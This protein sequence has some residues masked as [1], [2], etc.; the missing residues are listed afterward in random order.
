LNFFEIKIVTSIK[1]GH[2]LR[3]WPNHENSGHVLF[4]YLKYL[5]ALKKKVL[6]FYHKIKPKSE[7]EK[8]VNM[9]K[10]KRDVIKR[11]P[12]A[13]LHTKPIP[14]IHERQFP[15]RGWLCLVWPPLHTT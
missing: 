12:F 14:A 7:T 8:N 9:K 4:G 6:L 3:I 2:L 1:L 5:K 11:K 15:L 13:L 10:L